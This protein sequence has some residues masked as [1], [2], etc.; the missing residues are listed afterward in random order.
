MRTIVISPAALDV[1]RNYTTSLVERRSQ[2]TIQ[3]ARVDLA[4]DMW[5]AICHLRIGCSAACTTTLVLSSSLLNR[6]WKE[7]TATFLPHLVG[8]IPSVSDLTLKSLQIGFQLGAL[9]AYS[10]SLVCLT[11][12]SAT[13]DERGWVKLEFPLLEELTVIQEGVSWVVQ[14]SLP[15]L[16]G[17]FLWAPRL[18]HAS[19]VGIMELRIL[20]VQLYFKAFAATL[21]TGRIIGR[22]SFSGEYSVSFLLG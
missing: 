21:V 2:P 14:E 12:S 15:M 22:C 5:E 19:V 8:A 4:V 9:G 7:L 16:V 17:K 11:L 1:C 13:T 3:Q 10:S 6:D 20:G 18:Q